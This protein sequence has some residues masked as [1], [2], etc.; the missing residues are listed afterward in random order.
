MRKIH[1]LTLAL[2]IPAL[3]A[4]A[5]TRPP[6]D[7]LD[8]AS[9]SL[10]SARTAGAQEYAAA[11]YRSAGRRY[12][13][14]QSAEARKEYDDAARFARESTADSELATAKTRLARARAEVERLQR[15]NGNLDRDLNE[16][17]SPE[18]QP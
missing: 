14:A 3:Q 15:E 17:P 16:H 7:L 11:E 9:R 4:C 8:A 18:A 2:A 5:P 6:V 1:V 10:A 12:D 13:L